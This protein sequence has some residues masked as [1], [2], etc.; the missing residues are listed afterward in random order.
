MIFFKNARVLTPLSAVDGIVAVRGGCI[1]GVHARL[2]IPAGA[3]VID[4]RGLYLAPGFIDMHVHGGGGYGVMGAAPE[5][6]VKMCRAHA[7]F[8]T[9]SM[10]PTTLAAPISEVKKAIDAVRGAKGICKDCNI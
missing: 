4:A 2:D 6:V 1:Q 5:D 8:G 7:L 3:S 9:T 10:V